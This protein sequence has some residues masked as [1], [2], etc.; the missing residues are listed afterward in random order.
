MIKLKDI[1]KTIIFA[2]FIVFVLWQRL[3]REYSIK[4]INEY[5][6]NKYLIYGSLVLF[7]YLILIALF[8]IFKYELSLKH[9]G[10]YFS[11]LY[12]KFNEYFLKAYEP[13]LY[14]ISIHVDLKK[15]IEIPISYVVVYANY[16]K[17]LALWFTKLPAIIMATMFFVEVT[18][19]HKIEYFY[20]C[21]PLLLIPLIFNAC[22]FI[23]DEV[24]LAQI[25]YITP[26]MTCE[27]KGNR[28]VFQ[29][30]PVSPNI[31]NAL[32]LE[33][34]QKSLTWLTNQYQIF[35][36][37]KYFCDDINKAKEL[38]SSWCLLLTSLLYFISWLFICYSYH[39]NSLS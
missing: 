19:F 29:L 32:S 17:L 2:L 11:L 3:F 34:M 37:I 20:K 35:C 38:Y 26:H 18:Y 12:N 6:F 15:V 23:I 21:L 28:L 30:A 33:I 10:N 25:E 31:P 14:W 22:V 8:R 13:M 16:P 4:I 24:S 1:I 27:S 39:F 7:V 36:A 5:I 9:S